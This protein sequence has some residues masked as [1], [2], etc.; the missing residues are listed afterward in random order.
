M[1]I[2]LLLVEDQFLLRKLL[3]CK[4]ESVARL[5]IVG[6]AA[7]GAEAVRL[8]AKL[9]PHIVLMDLGLPK[10][11]GIEATARIRKKMP[12]VKVMALTVYNDSL[13]VSQM[14]KAGASGYVD[15]SSGVEELLSAIQSVANGDLY[16]SKAAA[17][18]AHPELTAKAGVG[19]SP[20][21]LLTPR[22]R[23]VLQ[24]L[25]EGKDSG[26]IAAEL[27]LSSATVHTY[28]RRIMEKLDLRSST[29]LLRYALKAS[30]QRD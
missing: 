2:K 11:D 16:L 12:E 3:V 17:H 26:E 4:L 19:T 10:L 9:K 30:L 20:Y 23:Q 25:G 1:A 6:E 5:S 15:K 21:D 8:A 22:E 28:R 7:D 13:R 24:L 14:L 27:G 29:R 18:A